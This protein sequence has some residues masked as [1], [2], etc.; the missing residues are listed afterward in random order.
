M[1]PHGDFHIHPMMAFYMYSMVFEWF[2]I[3]FSSTGGRYDAQD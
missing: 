2:D 3:T 1:E